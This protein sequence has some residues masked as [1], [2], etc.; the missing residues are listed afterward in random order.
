MIEESSR[1]L[2]KVGQQKDPSEFV[3]WLLNQLH[4]D[5]GGTS[6]PGSSIIHEVCT[7]LLIEGDHARHSK[8]S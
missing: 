2:F 8:V 3:T 4:V 7:K 6:R 1:H 5:L